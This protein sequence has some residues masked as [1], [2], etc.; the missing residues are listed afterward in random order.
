MNIWIIIGIV[1]GAGVI[2][3]DRYI[4]HLPNWLAVVLYTIAVILILV[5][6]I[7]SRTST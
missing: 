1:L 6:M 4:R 5:G 3:T 7:I 2:L